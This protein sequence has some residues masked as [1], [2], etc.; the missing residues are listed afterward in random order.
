MEAL[1]GDFRCSLVV[2]IYSANVCKAFCKHNTVLITRREE[3]TVFALSMSLSL[4]A[5]CELNFVIR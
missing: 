4:C 2:F 3:G 5:Q 1:T